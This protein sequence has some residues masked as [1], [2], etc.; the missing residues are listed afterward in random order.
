MNQRVSARHFRRFQ[1][2]H[3]R[4][5]P[6]ERTT[7]LDRMASA[8]GRFEPGTFLLGCVHTETFYQ[9]VMV[10]AKCLIWRGRAPA[11]LRIRRGVAGAPL[12]ALNFLPILMM[13]TL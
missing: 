6:S 12:P 13:Y 7:A 8:I 9:K 11:S 3:I 1:H 5:G 2:D 10:D 4:R